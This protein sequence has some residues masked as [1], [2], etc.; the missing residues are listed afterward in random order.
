VWITGKPI[1]ADNRTGTVGFGNEL[2]IKSFT[3]LN[4]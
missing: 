1:V 3:L 4:K 2:K